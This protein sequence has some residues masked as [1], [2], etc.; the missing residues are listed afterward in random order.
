V[1]VSGLGWPAGV[2]KGLC[3]CTQ[4]WWGHTSN[5]A[6]SF[7]PLTTRRTLRCPEKGNEAGEGSRE[8]VLG[9][10]LEGTGVA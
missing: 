8:Q 9:G 3:H 1:L 5:T 2:G 6:W 7:G 10:M 4:H